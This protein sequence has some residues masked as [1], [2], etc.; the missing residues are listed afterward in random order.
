MWSQGYSTW[1]SYLY[2]NNTT[3]K[4]V[5]QP[6]SMTTQ[7]ASRI[8]TMTSNLVCTW[9]IKNSAFPSFQEIYY[10][11]IKYSWRVYKQMIL[12]IMQFSIHAFYKTFHR[13]LTITILHFN[14][15]LSTFCLISCERLCSV[16]WLCV[17]Y[18]TGRC[19]GN[20]SY[21][22]GVISLWLT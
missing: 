7:L 19:T 15:F 4:Q 20:F 21:S 12:C 22:L 18:N 3:N 17:L 10:D 13:F 9:H 2:T 5:V 11:L 8:N 6:Y 1:H 14:R 16:C